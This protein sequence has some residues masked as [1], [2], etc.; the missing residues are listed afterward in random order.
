VEIN[1]EETS[2]NIT[3]YKKTP[4]IGGHLL[5]L[6]ACV[7]A[8]KYILY[9][10]GGGGWAAYISAF[11][12]VAHILIIPFRT[13]ILIRHHHLAFDLGDIIPHHIPSSHSSSIHIYYAK[14]AG[15]TFTCGTLTYSIFPAG[16]LG[17]WL[18]ETLH[19]YPV[20]ALCHWAFISFRGVCFLYHGHLTH[21]AVI[22][23]TTYVL[24]LDV[25][26]FSSSYSCM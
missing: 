18:S 1:R 26:I 5:C 7:R 25:S 14:R 24:Q 13:S 9:C 17:R 6:C 22:A 11:L 19:I 16:G 12:A 20:S 10:I 21:I 2:D 15:Y 23:H 8:T 4:F 3:C